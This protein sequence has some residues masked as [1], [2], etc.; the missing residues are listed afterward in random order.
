VD[1]FVEAC[2]AFA[3]GD[4]HLMF[5]VAD[6]TGTGIG[7]VGQDGG[8]VGLQV[9]TIGQGCTDSNNSP[10][11]K[12]IEPLTI[13][14]GCLAAGTEVEMADGSLRAVEDVMTSEQVQAD[15]SGRLL[16]VVDT[17]IGWEEHPLIRVETDSGQVL[18]MTRSHPVVVMD[19]GVRQVFLARQLEAGNVLV[20]A[21][22]NMTVKMVSQI[23]PPG[24]GDDVMV[25]NLGLGAADE[26]VTRDNTTFF[27]NGI[28]V[29]DNTMQEV[30]EREYEL[31]AASAVDIPEH[32]LDDHHYW[33]MQTI[34]TE[35]FESGDLSAWSAQIG[36]ARP[37]VGSRVAR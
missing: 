18:E 15:E 32:W 27:A 23:P 8:S 11:M 7:T 2:W 28:L 3:V 20:G 10:A 5:K 4:L 13:A 29:G 16:T 24:S 26:V 1:H 17:F 21:E 6:A 33:L 30:F 25:Y 35:G 22:G 34:F 12:C 14:V 36:A 37:V 19:D 31:N 9:G